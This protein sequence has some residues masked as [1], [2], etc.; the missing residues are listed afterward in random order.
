[1]EADY[2]DLGH[3]SQQLLGGQPVNGHADARTFDLYGVGLLPLGMVDLFAKAGGARW[4]LSGNL[5]GPN[6]TLSADPLRSGR[7]TG[8]ARAFSDARHRRRASVHVRADVYILKPGGR[9]LPPG[10]SV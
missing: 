2:V 7:G 4:T 1:V 10:W 6:S 8:R 9:E 3:Q 5:T